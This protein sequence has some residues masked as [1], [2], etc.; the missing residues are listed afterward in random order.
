MLLQVEAEEEEWLEEE[1]SKM[2]N[3]MMK[4]ESD[5]N[6]MKVYRKKQP[7]KTWEGGLKE[8]VEKKEG[9]KDAP[10]GR[11][12]GSV[13]KMDK[14]VKGLQQEG[15]VEVQRRKKLT[16]ESEGKFYWKDSDDLRKENAPQET[17]RKFR[18]VQ[19]HEI[20][21]EAYLVEQ[22]DLGD[23]SKSSPESFLQQVIRI[24]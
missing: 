13:V 9:G 22:E 10:V 4:K 16:V 6:Q 12:P 8:K 23:I 11:S 18:K 7:S 17:N 14:K 20:D 1:Q 2:I 15:E 21:D 19:F 5:E 24:H 3:D